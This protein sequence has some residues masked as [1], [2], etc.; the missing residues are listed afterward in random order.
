MICVYI[1]ETTQS[2][3]RTDDANGDLKQVHKKAVDEK[4]YKSINTVM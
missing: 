3:K 2:A 4:F 1:P